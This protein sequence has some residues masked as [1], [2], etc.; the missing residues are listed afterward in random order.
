M[1]EKK[2]TGVDDKTAEVPDSTPSKK[3]SGRSSKEEGRKKSSDDKDP[4]KKKS[5]KEK[6]ENDTDAAQR[7]KAGRPS[8]VKKDKADDP[9]KRKRDSGDEGGN[10]KKEDSK[11]KRRVEDNDDGSETKKDKKRV[12]KSPEKTGVNRRNA[13]LFTRKKEAAKSEEKPALKAEGKEEDDEEKG[14]DEQ[15][16]GGEFEFHEPELESPT[17]AELP[18]QMRKKGRKLKRGEE[19][20]SRGGGGCTGGPKIVDENLFKTYRQG[21]GLDTDTDTG[22]DSAGDGILSTSTD[23]DSSSDRQKLVT[24]AFSIKDSGQIPAVSVE[25]ITDHDQSNTSTLEE[26]VLTTRG[27]KGEALSLDYV[28]SSLPAPPIFPLKHVGYPLVSS[29]LAPEPSPRSTSPRFRVPIM[30]APLSATNHRS[31]PIS[32]PGLTNI[33]SILKKRELNLKK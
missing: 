8:K 32:P 3:K 1:K 23:D 20:G 25:T 24:Q 11:K 13:V 18:S 31:H 16:Q 14:T 5:S 4:S 7:K 19:R 26:Q 29:L 27:S 21:G 30:A 9:K 28:P 6:E 22:A 15:K 17:A 2:E 33:V 10:E 12:E